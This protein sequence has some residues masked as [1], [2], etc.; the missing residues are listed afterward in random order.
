MQLG[1]IPEHRSIAV[2]YRVQDFRVRQ[3]PTAKLRVGRVPF[4]RFCELSI[5]VSGPTA[6]E[7][8]DELSR[9]MAEQLQSLK[10]QVFGGLNEEELHEQEE[11]LK[12]IRQ[13]SADYLAALKREVR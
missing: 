9:L 6:K 8:R 3:S 4:Q 1:A 10:K 13:V 5:K 7:L 11:R 12:R 2:G